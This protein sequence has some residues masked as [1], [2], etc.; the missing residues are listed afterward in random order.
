MRIVS[1]G[2]GF[3]ADVVARTPQESQL[4]GRQAFECASLM[5]NIHRQLK[6]NFAAVCD[7]RQLRA[8]VFGGKGQQYHNDI[9]HISLASP[10]AQT[11][12][13]PVEGSPIPSPRYG[14]RYA[15]ILSRLIWG[16]NVEH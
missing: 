16:R 6:R 9:I 14:A 8:F 3:A 1:A 7:D 10:F 12:L 4:V 5:T 2:D 11:V 13:T 15:V